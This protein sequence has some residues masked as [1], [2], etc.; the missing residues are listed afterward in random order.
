MRLSLWGRPGY[1][2]LS[3]PGVIAVKALA[4]ICLYAVLCFGTAHAAAPSTAA[5]G[6]DVATTPASPRPDPCA[7]PKREG[8]KAAD[9][10]TPATGKSP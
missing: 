7:E 9:K 5:S 3:S 4:L 10:K 1:N 8:K 6:G 2:S